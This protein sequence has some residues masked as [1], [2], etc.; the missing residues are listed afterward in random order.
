MRLVY[1]SI[2]QPRP[3]SVYCSLTVDGVSTNFLTD[4]GAEISLLPSTHDAV[5]KHAQR[6]K[7][8]DVQP[9]TVDGNP[10]PLSGILSVSLLINESPI[11]VS[12]YITTDDK[13][14]PI[15]GLDVMRK[16]EFVAINFQNNSVTFG[17][18]RHLFPAPLPPKL[19]EVRHISVYRVE[20]DSDTSIPPRHEVRIAGNLIA[21]DKEDLASLHGKTLLVEPDGQLRE[22]LVCARSLVTGE[23]GRVSICICNPF[24]KEVKV[25]GG[26]FVGKAEVI[27]SESPVIANLQ[28]DDEIGLMSAGETSESAAQV[29]EALC[30]GAEVSVQERASLYKFLERYQ[31][32]FSI[33]GEMGRYMGDPFTIDTGQARP[34][35]QMPRPVPYHR[36]AEVD[37]Q[38]E[39]MLQKDIIEPA[40]S[41]WAS[42]ILLVRKSDGTLRFCIDYRKLN[43]VTSMMLF[44]C[45]TL[46]TVLTPLEWILNYFLL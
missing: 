10:I 46:M 30:K 19:P 37:R 45:S 21:S 25:N 43:A 39:D 6:L 13:M 33:K 7:P 2:I 18:E 41:E 20:I 3:N 9:V 4:S 8:S 27:P 38:L 35:R 28:E 24:D 44:P 36:K 42:P 1:I 5:L 11:T 12:F 40:N 16:F 17:P 32:V 15:L 22:N 23:G 29:I 26:T 34:I 14:P 31:D